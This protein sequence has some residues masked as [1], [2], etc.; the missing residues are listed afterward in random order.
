MGTTRFIQHGNGRMAGSIGSGRDG[1]PTA[2]AT[3]AA[4]A[5]SPLTAAA[6]GLA[7]VA[8]RL[9]PAADSR[10]EQVMARLATLPDLRL[11]PLG[12]CPAANAL[13]TW[14]VQCL[15]CAERACG[16]GAD[17]M[18][19]VRPHLLFKG[20]RT[21]C[22]CFKR[23]HTQASAAAALA[24]LMPGWLPAGHY[25][26]TVSGDWNV[27][28]TACGDTLTSSLE[29]IRSLN[30]KPQCACRLND[31]SAEFYAALARFPR[32]ED[33]PVVQLVEPS[34]TF[35]GL[36]TECGD[37]VTVDVARTLAGSGPRCACDAH[38]NQLTHE[39]AVAR[40]S[41]FRVRVDTAFPGIKRRWLM[42][43]LDCGE[44]RAPTLDQLDCM[45]TIGCACAQRGRKP[46]DEAEV[47]ARMARHG[48]VTVLEV[49][50]VDATTL[51]RTMCSK[52]HDYT[53]SAAAAAARGT[54]CG[55]CSTLGGYREDRPGFFYLICGSHDGRP[56]VKFGISNVVDKRLARHART[57]MGE[58]LFVA[59]FEDGATAKSIE[60]ACKS[61]MLRSGL[62]SVTDAGVKFDGSTES[63]YTPWA[64]AAVRQQYASVAAV[65]ARMCRQHGHFLEDGTFV[66]DAAGQQAAAA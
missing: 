43:C 16:C 2:S 6:T 37:T 47:R 62:T 40:L 14:P 18:M 65:A 33:V 20:Q 45:A 1:V 13:E 21:S 11:R 26:G 35:P 27:T 56:V 42:T 8:E 4:Q 22:C 30:L 3:I 63:F 12:P 17:V 32:I 44:Q 66:E 53:D 29:R 7:G 5:R 52:G 31:V 46:L 36:C 15:S 23:R 9:R 41:R 64:D 58:R 39:Q 38:P 60:S 54:A 34:G 51:V 61:M 48:D 59:R 55:A 50:R 10:T 57:G 25:P 19:H 49:V 24:Q 28:C